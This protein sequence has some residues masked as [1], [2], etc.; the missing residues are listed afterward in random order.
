MLY[1]LKGSMSDLRDRVILYIHGGAYVGDLILPQLR[2]LSKIASRTNATIII[3]MYP[4]APKHTY[5]AAYDL[6]TRIYGDLL[7]EKTSA[8]IYFMGESAGGGFILA[9]SEYLKT[10]G[11][12]QPGNIIMLSPWLDVSM[13]N[14]EIA[15]YERLDTSLSAKGLV[16]DGRAWAGTLDT[17][18]YLVSPIYGDLSGL[19]FISVFVGSHE[20]FYPDCRLLDRKLDELGID[21]N[22]Y[23]YEGQGHVF[24][25]MPIKE[26]DMA[27]GQISEIIL[28]G[29]PM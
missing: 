14:P 10:V 22:Y 28:S 4:L 23:V 12:P 20:I 17:K 6:M 21:H 26:A 29:K 8:E 19:G 13:T 9:F 7:K 16:I 1:S 3:P 2:M 25:A 5:E 24:P 27:I 11:M 18:N 15:S